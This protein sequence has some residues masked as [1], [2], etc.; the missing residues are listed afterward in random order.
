MAV[1]PGAQWRPLPRPS[2]TRMSRYDLVLLHTTVGSFEGTD[3]YFRRLTNGVNSHFLTGGYGE[4]R[5]LV[6]TAVRSGASGAGNHR[7]ISIENA[8]MG[9]GFASWNTNNGAD[10]PAFTAA[11]LEANARI[12]AWAHLTHGVPLVAAD[13]SRPSARGVGYH[14]L[15]CNPWRVSD[16]ELWSSSTGK[17]CPGNR[18]IAQ[19]PQI[20]ARA[21]QIVAGAPA[22]TGEWDEMASREEIKTA[23]IEASLDARVMDQTADHTW[24]HPLPENHGVPILHLL[25]IQAQLAG[26][27]AAV[28]TLAAGAAGEGTTPDEL[29]AVIREEMANV[30]KLVDVRV[31]VADET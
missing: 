21:R 26:L 13:T 5:Q 27:S 14:R 1:M 10:V 17:V 19:I 8:D 22:A 30:A 18:R 3:G 16:G 31:S 15:G 24:R 11:Q 29:R 7:S 20:I 9:P 28:T 6:D 23:L 12:C 25:S 2:S 4:I